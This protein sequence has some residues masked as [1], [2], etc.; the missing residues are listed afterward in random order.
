MA[1][2]KQLAP[3]LQVD[4]PSSPKLGD[5]FL[6]QHGDEA[7]MGRC[8]ETPADLMVG[9]KFF[10]NRICPFAHRAWWAALEVEAPIEYVHVDMGS[11]HATG[12]NNKP[13]WYVNDVSPVATVPTLTDHGIPYFAVAGT[14]EVDPVFDHVVKQGARRLGPFSAVDERRVR[15]FVAW[16]GGKKLVPLM[17]QLLASRDAKRTATLKEK[18]TSLIHEVNDKFAAESAGPFFLGSELSQA[19]MSIAPFFDR[20]EATLLHYRRYEVLPRADPG[21]AKLISMMDACRSRPAFQA[22]S[23][24]SQFYVDA[25]KGYGGA[26]DV[27]RAS[28]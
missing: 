28:L 15:M 13:W 2:V 7:P 8:D 1:A 5:G 27:V 14:F 23:Q 9:L 16:L 10:G 11:K 18:L 26:P 24:D 17:Y 25:Y 4:A 6:I 20:F 19:D 12:P 22:T 3:N 21:C